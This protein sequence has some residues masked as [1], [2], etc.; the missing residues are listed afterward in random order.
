MVVDYRPLE[1]F[2]APL[3]ESCRR[4]EAFQLVKVSSD[5]LNDLVLGLPQ[6]V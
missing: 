5:V 1:P 3:I 4:E 6:V 2:F